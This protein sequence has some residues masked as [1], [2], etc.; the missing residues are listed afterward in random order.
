MCGTTTKYKLA[1]RMPIIWRDIAEKL[2][3]NMKVSIAR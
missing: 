3:Y 2:W 1:E